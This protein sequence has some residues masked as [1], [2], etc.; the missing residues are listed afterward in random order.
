MN[1]FY[2]WT[3][4]C[5]MNKADSEYLAAELKQLGL[6]QVPQIDEADIIVLN[7]CAI[8]QNAEDKVLNKLSNLKSLKQKYPETVLAI[9]GCMVSSNIDD[10]KEKFPY[11]DFFLKPRNFSDLLTH[12]KT[13][14]PPISAINANAPSQ[15]P[16]AF[17]PIIQGCNNFCSY[18]I[19]PYRRGREKSR[20]LQEIID[21]I[22]QLAEEGTR[23]ITLLGQNVDSYGHD[24][25]GKPDLADLLREVNQINNLVR[26]RFLTSHPKDMS[27]KLIETIASLDK[28][29]EHISLPA[30]SGDNDI[31][32]AMRRGYTIEQYI[33]LIN[34]IR[35]TIPNVALSNDIIVGFPNETQE[36]FQ[37]TFD[38]LETYQFDTV[39][40]AAYSPR[41]GTIAARKLEDNVPSEEKQRRLQ[42]VEELQE[43]ISIRKNRQLLD[44]TVGVLVE[45]TKGDRWQ[46]R[47]RSDKLVFFE[48]EGDC[49]GQLVQV[50]IDHTGPW[51]LQGSPA[52][53]SNLK[54]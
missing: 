53:V 46:S 9:T 4:G 23:E 20:P 3:I 52:M 7:T 29:C 2:I 31:L 1:R 16:T 8:R 38:L 14:A 39:H 11:V 37:R 27:Q 28:V 12:T 15:S 5:Q 25:P 51:S 6:R 17:V 19:V 10:M 44:Q 40:V 33:E 13:H 21:E 18:C 42:L 49:L 43:R 32:T 48:H 45:G 22:Q 50:K 34:R 47:T 54:Y 36:Q 30:Q 24:L 41:P 35:A 26:I